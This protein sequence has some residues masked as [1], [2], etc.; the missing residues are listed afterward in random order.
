VTDVSTSGGQYDYNARVQVRIRR[1]GTNSA[2]SGA[3][4]SI[5]MRDNGGYTTT[6]FCTT[7]ST[8]LCSVT[9]NRPEYRSPVLAYVYSVS[10][11]PS[12]DQSQAY[13][14]LYNTGW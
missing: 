10:S 12:W 1:T 2:V 14:Y 9:W 7:G 8:G 6:K 13:T 3:S 4:V 5:Y 11:N